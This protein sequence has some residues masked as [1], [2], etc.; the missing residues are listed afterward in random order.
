MDFS[1][2]PY[3]D[4]KKYA[5]WMFSPLSSAQEVKDWVR[6]Y[7]GLELPL[8]ITD[9][10]S[11]SSPLDSIYQV[12]NTFKHNTGDQNPGYILMSC[13]EGMKTVSVAILEV[14]LV[15]HFQLEVGHAAAT[16]DQ[17]SVALGYIDTFFMSIQPLLDVAGWLN[18]TKNKRLTKFKTPQG[19]TPYIKIVICTTKGMNSLHSNVLFLDELDLA[20][21]AAIKEGKNITGF[22]KGIHGIK[23]YLSTRKYAFGNMSKAIDEAP[24]MHYKILSWNILDVTER[25]P[26]SRHLPEE[27]KTDMYVAK[28]LP[29]KQIFKDEFEFL[30]TAEHPKWDLVKD[31]YK[32]CQSCLLLPV[33]RKRLADKPESAS[34]GFYKPIVSVIQKFRE[35]DP[36]TAEAQLLCWKPGS[37]GLVYPR[38][39]TVPGKGN[40]MSLKDAYEILMG[41]PSTKSFVSEMDFLYELQKSNIPLYAGV[42]W[43]YVHDSVIIVFAVFPTGEVWIVDCWAAPGLEFSDVLNTAISYRE[44]HK[45]IQKWWCDQAMPSHTKSFTKNGMKSPKFTKD[46][47]GGI[48][49]LR[50]KIV[51]SSGKRMLKIVE[52]PNTKRVISAIQKHRFKLDGQGNVTLEPDDERGIADICDAARYVGQNIFP[53]RGDQKISTSWTE[54]QLQEKNNPN[55]TTNEQMREEIFKRVYDGGSVTGSTTHQKGGFKWNI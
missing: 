22:S 34:G 10:D 30:P 6:M 48:E 13:R 23:V 54:A 43:G 2:L 4:Q 25:C 35:N 7:L 38:F 33:C 32:G 40:V 50:S 16:E 37:E 11:T 49:S 3:E 21:P 53:V 41:S 9:P 15:L 17:S 46:V 8:E 52:T 55:P 47:M 18:K 39:S 26:K 20:D 29:L 24:A 36:D 51:D 14:L 44:K 19:K 31:V 5:E 28:N 27:E 1:I 12:Y 42:D 45:N